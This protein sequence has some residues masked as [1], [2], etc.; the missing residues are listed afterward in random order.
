MKKQQRVRSHDLVV[1]EIDAKV[2]G[3][4]VVPPEL[5]GAIVSSHYFVYTIDTRKIDHKY[6][7]F[8]LR[9]GKPTRDI[10]P[11]VKGSHNYASVRPN[12]IMELTIPLPSLDKQRLIAS[13]FENIQRLQ[14]LLRESSAETE[15]MILALFQ[16]LLPT[17]STTKKA[18]K[19][20]Q[21]TLS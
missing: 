17:T 13:A 15:T 20:I 7:E 11:F 21:A 8:Y 18:A 4:G 14:K 1:A 3:F 9:T 6:L 2:G 12:A 5:D 16:K 10:Q 19:G